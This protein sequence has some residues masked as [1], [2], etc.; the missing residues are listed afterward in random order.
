MT[1]GRGSAH[2]GSELSGDEWK[3]ISEFARTP[4]HL[5]RPELLLPE[6]V[7]GEE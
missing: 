6:D 1:I 2:M 3:R 7:S 4:E 5:R